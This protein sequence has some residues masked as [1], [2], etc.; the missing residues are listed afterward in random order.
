MKLLS[1]DNEY[2]QKIVDVDV[3]GTSATSYEE[4]LFTLT[5]TNI[6]NEFVDL[7]YEV[8]TPHSM[9]RMFPRFG[10]EQ[11][12]GLDFTIIVDGTGQYRRISWDGYELENLLSVGDEL[13]I[14]YRRDLV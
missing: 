13:L 11:H 12:Y 4:E 2:R 5:S 9:T 10:P 3:G 6:T 14:A 8:T 1:I 7:Q